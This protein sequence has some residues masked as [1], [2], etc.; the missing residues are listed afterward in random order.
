MH[1]NPNCKLCK[2]IKI[3]NKIFSEVHEM[4]LVQDVPKTRVM[5]WLN[6]QLEIINA[7]I[8]EEEEKIDPF[9]GVNFH[10]H[11]KNHIKDKK[12]YTEVV[13]NEEK[14]FLASE[15]FTP[16]E[17]IIAASLQEDASDDDY[18]DY[19]DI[20]EIVDTF[21]KALKFQCYRSFN[22]RMD[23][24]IGELKQLQ[25]LIVNH[26]KLKKDISVTRKS[27]HI[28]GAAIER[29]SKDL[30]KS[31]LGKLKEVSKDVGVM[32]ADQT[33][34]E[35]F[36]KDI[37]NMIFEQIRKHIQTEVSDIVKMVKRVYKIK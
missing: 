21:D 17:A 24:T 14:K 10:T 22:E 25:E 37:Q 32:I 23:L 28:A 35:K 29:L 5:N 16:E 7:G 13:L 4:V 18:K 15:V 19:L 31:F 36:A 9:N 2:L 1:L 20:N 6:K 30:T 34:S 3:N 11:F 26:S 27:D 33:D 8:E 12:N